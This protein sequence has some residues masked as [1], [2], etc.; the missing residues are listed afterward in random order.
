LLQ[1]REETNIALA[2]TVANAK[3]IDKAYGKGEPVAP[4][5][6]VIFFGAVFL[7]LIL[8][9]IFLY[10][11]DILDNKV[12]GKRDIDKIGVPFLGDI[13][14]TDSKNK[15][16]VSKGDSSSVAEA[17]RLLRTNVDF[18]M[19]GLKGS[20]RTIFL[21]STLGKE[22]KSFIALNLASS[23]AISGKKVLLIGMDVRAPKILEY[24]DLENTA[25][26]TNY[27]SDPEM[28]LEQVILKKSIN[29]NLDILPSGAIPPNPAEL[30][31]N[32]RVQTMFDYV[33]TK[34]DYIIVDTAPIGMV[35]DT[36]L[37]SKY[38]D[39]FVYVVR[40][41]YLD[42]RLLSVAEDLYKEKRLP[43]MAILIN[44]TDKEKGYGYGYGYGYG[45]YGY[46]H[47]KPRPFW[48]RLF[49]FK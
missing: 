7:G 42:R 27:I 9:I 34:Y 3:I 26:L 36:L 11:K 15:I 46:G 41:Y 40:A 35:T 23:I 4:K 37:L 47:E 29:E 44:G 19:S 49:G 32:E 43:N 38:A 45:G 14:N 1:K 39:A 28:D 16:V 8:P 6:K 17:F 13:P 18:M 5:K 24:L 21:T 25:G 30:L 22:G 12:H 48:K 20:G 10:I 2:V 31:M 33:R